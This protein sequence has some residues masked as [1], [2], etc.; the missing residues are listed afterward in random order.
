M[1]IAKCTIDAL[2]YQQ[3]LSLTAMSILVIDDDSSL[4]RTVRMSRELLTA[5]SE[6]AAMKLGIDRTTLYRESKKYGI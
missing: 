6:K 4:R 3:L 1:R 2:G 5:V